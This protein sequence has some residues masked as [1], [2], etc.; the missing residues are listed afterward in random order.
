MSG[1]KPA[2][3]RILILCAACPAE[4]ELLV[5]EGAGHGNSFN[6]DPETY[7]DAVFRFVERYLPAEA[8]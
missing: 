7:F 6:H 3:K 8:S 5:V 4:K 2:R 1:K